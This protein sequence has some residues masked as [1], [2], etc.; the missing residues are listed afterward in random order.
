MSVVEPG[1]ARRDGRIATALGIAPALLLGE[2]GDAAFA[3]PVPD[4]PAVGLA[5]CAGIADAGALRQSCSRTA[6]A[7]PAKGNA[8]SATG[9]GSD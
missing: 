7:M 4:D 1:A 3:Q 8:H 9:R 2:P 6:S 5:T